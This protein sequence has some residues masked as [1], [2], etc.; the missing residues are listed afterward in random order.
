MCFH[1]SSLCSVVLRQAN[2][3]LTQLDYCCNAASAN[4]L[5]SFLETV[6]ADKNYIFH[7]VCK[8]PC[9]CQRWCVIC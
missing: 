4:V 2:R 7:K 6:M 8:N 3:G 5:F 1:S 9:R